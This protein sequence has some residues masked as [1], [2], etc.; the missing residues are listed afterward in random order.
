M[1]TDD[2]DLDLATDV[3]PT[4]PIARAGKTDVAR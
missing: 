2:R 3:C 1:L 4:D